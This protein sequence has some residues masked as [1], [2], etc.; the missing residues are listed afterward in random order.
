MMID[1]LAE[2]VK[3]SCLSCYVMQNL[4]P[5]LHTSFEQVP[6]HSNTQ[7]NQLSSPIA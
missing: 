6:V 1:L 3:V 2:G 5:Q 4:E 7:K